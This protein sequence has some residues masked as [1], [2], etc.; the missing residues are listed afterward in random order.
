VTFLNLGCG[1]PPVHAPKPWV[2]VDDYAGC[3]PDLLCNI[4]QLP[5]EDGSVQAVYC[6][7]VLE[8]ME[9][10][11]DVPRLLAEIRR[12]LAPDGMLMVVGPDYDRVTASPAWAGAVA[13]VRWG[14]DTR[15]GS[16]HRWCP[17]AWAHLNVIREVFPEAHEIDIASVGSFWPLMSRV[18][19]QFAITT[20]ETP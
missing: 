2:N 6:G 11:L 9:L 12:V 20:E 14:D 5:H 3:E 18:G 15:P 19:W 1:D 8:H 16:R 10:A 4:L 17:T 13:M 7:H